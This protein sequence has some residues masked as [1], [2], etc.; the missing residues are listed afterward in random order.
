M[1]EGFAT[2]I[3]IVIV[4][5]VVFVGAIVVTAVRC[6]LAC[7]KSARIDEDGEDV[8]SANHTVQDFVL[9]VAEEHELEAPEAK[10]KS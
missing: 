6:C 2:T 4:C 9:S 7:S 1:D 10:A 8:P 3:F 5:A